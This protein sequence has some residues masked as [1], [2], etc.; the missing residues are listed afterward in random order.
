MRGDGARVAFGVGLG[1]AVVFVG[2]GVGV[3]GVGDE[4]LVGVTVASVSVGDAGPFDPLMAQPAM[5]IEADNPTNIGM[6]ELNLMKSPLIPL[7]A[8]VNWSQQHISG[9]LI[10][11]VNWDSSYDHHPG[12]ELRQRGSRDDVWADPWGCAWSCI[13]Q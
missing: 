9:T 4:L 2:L 3:G 5:R 8:C 12:V 13:S 1:C 6:A 11:I 7:L 10:R